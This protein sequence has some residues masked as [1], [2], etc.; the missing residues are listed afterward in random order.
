MTALGLNV[1]SGSYVRKRDFRFTLRTPRKTVSVFAQRLVERPRTELGGLTMPFSLGGAPDGNERRRAARVAHSVPV[2]WCPVST[3]TTH[4]SPGVLHNLS[5]EGFC[6]L[7]DAEIQVGGLLTIRLAGNVESWQPW[8]HVVHST[9][10][11]EQ[12][13]LVGCRFIGPPPAEF[14]RKLSK[15][16]PRNAA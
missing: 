10:Q 1:E 12:I 4:F 2:Q 15:A 6:L 7:V 14:L 3:G 16:G 5:A 13:W 9:N 8:A 11:Q